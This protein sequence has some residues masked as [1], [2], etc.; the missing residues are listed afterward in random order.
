[1]LVTRRLLLRRWRADDRA[2]F[3]AIN[4]DPEVMRHFPK[5]LAQEESDAL[6]VRL[7]DRW[8]AD[9]FGFAAVERR[10]DGVLLGMVGLSR[11]RFGMGFPLDGAVEVGW[12]LAPAHWGEGY[13]TEAARA[14]L[15]Y[16]FGTIGLGEI[17]AFTV[18]ANERSQLL[19]RRLGLRR[20]PA[21]DF[22]LPV[23][24]D[25]HPLRAHLVFAIDR[26]SWEAQAGG[27]GQAG[28]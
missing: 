11:V 14:W 22:E 3:G 15:A 19:M 20:D 13:A 26:T 23:L 28:D 16:G 18:P 21:R 8:Q 1:M 10:A 24:P 25:G 6:L 4:A 5:R 2:A 7:Q 12:R 17:I 27:E 9:G